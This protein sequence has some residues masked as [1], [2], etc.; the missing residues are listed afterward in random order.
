MHG[1]AQCIDFPW[2]RAHALPYTYRDS[3]R[4]LLD[5]HLSSLVSVVFR[6][7]ARKFYR[8]SFTDIHMF[9]STPIIYSMYGLLKYYSYLCV[10]PLAVG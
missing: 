4:L 1:H 9:C 7:F 5:V 6:G 10:K 3:Q 2:F 8:T